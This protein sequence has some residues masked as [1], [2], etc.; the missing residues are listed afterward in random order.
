MVTLRVLD[1]VPRLRCARFLREFRKT[2]RKGA[3]RPGF[4]VVHYSIQND[5]AHFVVEA[6]GRC[7]W[8]TG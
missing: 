8:R 2:L 4:R 7:A 5:H 6:Q 3:R 1:D